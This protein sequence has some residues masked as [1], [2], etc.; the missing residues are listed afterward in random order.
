MS[1][2]TPFKRLLR[3]NTAT[4]T[5][6]EKA[7]AATAEK[8][9]PDIYTDQSVCRVLGIRRRVLADARTKKGRGVDWDAIGNEV[10]MTRDW[11]VRFAAEFQIPLDSSGLD[12]LEPVSGNFVSVR[13][14]GS[15]GLN[16][17][18][19]MVEYEASGR[20]GFARVR[21]QRQYPIHYLEV[22]TC[23]VVDLPADRHIEWTA[24]QNTMKY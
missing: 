10:G 17:E 4:A 19:V 15:A 13:C 7:E 3:Q 14:V 11:I 24:A 9:K 5:A 22:F 20:R 23:E 16:L 6:D 1:R 2:N 12:G 21:N 8:K 18:K